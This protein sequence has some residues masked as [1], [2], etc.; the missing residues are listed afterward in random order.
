ML[1]YLTIK[2]GYWQPNMFISVSKTQ[3]CNLLIFIAR[4][5]SFPLSASLRPRDD[6]E[7]Y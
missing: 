1:E 5:A 4:E 7:A 2:R 3:E 6:G